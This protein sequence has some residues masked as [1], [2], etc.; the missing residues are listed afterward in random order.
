MDPSWLDGLLNLR[1]KFIKT[2]LVEI[3]LSRIKRVNPHSLI[4]ELPVQCF[5][6]KSPKITGLLTWMFLL[7]FSGGALASDNLEYDRTDRLGQSPNSVYSFLMEVSFLKIDVAIVEY[8]LDE[9]EAEKVT[10]VI[11]GDEQNATSEESI[12]NILLDAEAMAFSM[13]FQRDMSCS[14]LVKLMR[15]NLDQGLDN[16]TITEKEHELVLTRFTEVLVVDEG[17]ELLEGDNLKY[18]VHKD[19]V[20]IIL[21][22]VEGEMLIDSL[23]SGSAWTKAIKGSFLG[24]ESR[25]WENLVTVLWPSE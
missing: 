20:R 12:R 16:N 9:M 18:V 6:R 5:S 1:K 3:H 25:L 8:Q 14:R 10:A 2:K 13:K 19:G 22:G 15:K 11:A 4:K 24:S 21:V 17:R 7:T 23:E